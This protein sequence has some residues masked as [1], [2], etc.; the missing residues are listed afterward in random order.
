M[1]SSLTPFALLGSLL[2]AATAALAAEGPRGQV[3]EACKADV[4]KLCADVK[5]GG[6]RIAACLKEKK[7][8]MSPECKAD[9]AKQA[10]ER[11]ESPKS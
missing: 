4:K 1:R 6:G 7:D 5:P 11:K 3:T 2:L 9:L 10:A 8:Q